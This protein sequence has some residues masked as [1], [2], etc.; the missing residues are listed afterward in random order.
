MV[1]PLFDSM[2]NKFI[3]EKN[4]LVPNLTIPAIRMKTIMMRIE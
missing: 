4:T 2:V 3:I 1:K